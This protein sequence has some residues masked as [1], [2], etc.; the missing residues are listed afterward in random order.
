ML[1]PE[2]TLNIST[3]SLEGD[4]E[5]TIRLVIRKGHEMASLLQG[6]A[7]YPHVDQES[8]DFFRHWGNWHR[9][10]LDSTF[11]PDEDWGGANIIRFPIERRG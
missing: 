3:G 5:A 2:L 4:F 7:S 8:A 9:D 1:D 6:L 11:P 10:W